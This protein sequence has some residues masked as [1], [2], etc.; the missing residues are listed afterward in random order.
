MTKG[1]TKILVLGGGYAGVMAAL[2]LAGKTRR[3]QTEITLVNGLNHFVERLRL[4]ETVV[5]K[6]TRQ[7]AMTEMLRGTAVK[8]V[9]GWATAIAPEARTV[10]ISTEAGTQTLP[11]D[12]LVYALGSRIEQ[13]RVPGVEEHA[14]LLDAFGER[15][16]SALQT[17]LA[18]LR[19]A[20]S[21]LVAGGGATGIEAACEIKAKHP[22]TAVKLLSSGDV[23][24]FK[25][26]TIQT[27]MLDALAEQG[28][29][30]LEN[31]P[32]ASVSETGVALPDGRFLDAQVTVWCGG[33]QVP[34][35]AKVAGLPV[36][37]QNQLLV[38]PFLR[39]TACDT[40]YAVGDAASPVEDPGTPVRMS[41]LV[42]LITG[43]LAADNITAVLKQK[44]QKP[45]SF[46]TYGQA[47]ALGP[48]D[49]VGFNTF[50]ADRPV[51]PIFRRKTAVKLRNFFVWMLFAF[52]RIE[53]RLPGFFFWV[54]QGR[55]ARQQRKI[56]RLETAVSPL[57]SGD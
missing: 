36:N 22:Q 33:F 11:Y 34:D 12:Y 56:K 41:L 51:G 2:R 28:I 23:G 17:R 31:S 32:V 45:L 44:Q 53:R 5:G 1:K 24:G 37:R 16:A 47:I 43:A 7:P 15:S 25:G 6:Q 55:Y 42:A 9:Q 20:D 4:H 49:A 30:L 27:H 26:V 39:S 10:T 29:E 54:G 40:I 46:A 19:P 14:Y 57:E 18:T 13:Q 52:L 21:V 35:L 38:D 3:L 48:E 50:P 8:F